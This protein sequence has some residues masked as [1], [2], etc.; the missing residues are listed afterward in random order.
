MGCL[1]FY[2]DKR[3]LLTALSKTIISDLNNMRINLDGDISLLS[4]HPGIKNGP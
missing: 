3:K 4:P 1:V 2:L